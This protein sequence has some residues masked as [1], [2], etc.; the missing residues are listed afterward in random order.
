MFSNHYKRLLV[1]ENLKYRITPVSGH[2]ELEKKIEESRASEDL[3][4]VIFINCG[5]RLDL[6]SK[7]FYTETKRKVRTILMDKHRPIHHRNMTAGRRIIVIGAHFRNYQ[8]HFLL[9]M[10]L[11]V[12]LQ[13][14]L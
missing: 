14:T 7:W 6:T 2:I 4:Y 5:S 9:Y 12:D 8:H 11:N 3:K 10:T 1:S 13:N